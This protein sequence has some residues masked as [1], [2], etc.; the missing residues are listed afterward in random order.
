MARQLLSEIN[1]AL[2]YNLES[3][4][5]NEDGETHE[6]IEAHETVEQILYASYFQIHFVSIL[7]YI[8]KCIRFT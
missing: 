2:F 8:Q 7:I 4:Y 1:D 6:D 3:T 5:V